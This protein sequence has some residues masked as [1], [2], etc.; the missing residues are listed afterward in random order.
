M[1]DHIRPHVRAL[2][3]R[4]AQITLAEWKEFIGNSYEMES[5]IPRLDDEAFAAYA[6]YCLANCYRHERVRPCLTYDDALAVFVV[7]ELLRRL[8]AHRSP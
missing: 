8:V 4:G 2:A 1:T 5:I 7:P 6:A 3:E